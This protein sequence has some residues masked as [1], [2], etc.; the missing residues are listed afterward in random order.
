MCAEQQ[1][2]Q[3]RKVPKKKFVHFPSLTE[4]TTSTSVN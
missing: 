3:Q 1:Q 2:Q 4:A